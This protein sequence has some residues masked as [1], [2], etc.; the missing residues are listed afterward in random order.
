MWPDWLKA[1]QLKPR[2]LFGFW[3][4][5]SLLLLLPTRFADVMGITTLRNQY[6]GW[7]GLATLAAFA[8][9]LVQL[10]PAIRATKHGKQFRDAVLNSL[11]GLTGQ[12]RFLLAYCIHT[13][14]RTVYLKLTD[15]AGQSLCNQ[16]L[17]EKAG[18]TGSML[19]WPHTMPMFVWAYIRK[20]P[21]VLL[22]DA[23]W[24]SAELL[25]AFKQFEGHTRSRWY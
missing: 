23:D 15:S 8:F 4:L 24:R 21:K 10:I 20:N 12:E 2:F 18:G 9:W 17:L 5:G 25:E 14:Q 16:G 11:N 7:I 22:S 6:R 3:L 13:N 19:T 1:I